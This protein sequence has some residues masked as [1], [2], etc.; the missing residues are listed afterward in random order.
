VDDAIR[1]TG[2]PVS[3][4]VRVEQALDAVEA[5]LLEKVLASLSSNPAAKST[6]CDGGISSSTSHWRLLAIVR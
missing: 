5:G 1:H 3:G 2:R 4:Q 6:E